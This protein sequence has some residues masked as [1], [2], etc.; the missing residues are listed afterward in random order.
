[1]LHHDK[2]DEECKD[3]KQTLINL[4]SKFKIGISEI[5]K[6]NE[7][8]QSE[9]RSMAEYKTLETQFDQTLQL[10]KNKEY[11]VSVMG[12]KLKFV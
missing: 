5:L 4:I 1:M 8:E 7:I 10:V 2:L 6:S 11:F 9:I 3:E 12:E